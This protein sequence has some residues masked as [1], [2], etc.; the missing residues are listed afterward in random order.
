MRVTL[1]LLVNDWA[2]YFEYLSTKQNLVVVGGRV[3]VRLEVGCA[4]DFGF[5]FDALYRF[6]SLLFLSLARRSQLLKFW[7]ASLL[8][9]GG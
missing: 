6:T 2:G 7:V 1:G 8:G 5:V 3:I 9:S 4:G